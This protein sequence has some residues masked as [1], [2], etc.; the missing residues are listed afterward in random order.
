MEP[1]ITKNTLFNFF[2][3]NATPLQKR[4]IEQWLEEEAN[5][6]LFFEW[7]KQWE[8]EH[9]QFVADPEAAFQK[10]R[11]KRQSTRSNRHKDNSPIQPKR[12]VRY[13]AIAACVLLAFLWAGWLG[14]DL[15][16]WKT[17]RT[18]FG[19]LCTITL[20]EG[21]R[22]VLNANSSLAV[23]RF[24]FGDSFRQVKLAGEAQFS[25]KHTLSHQRFIVRTPDGLAVEVLGT[26]FVVYSRARGSRVVLQSG[27]VLIRNAANQLLSVA[28]GEVITLDPAGAFRKQTPRDVTMYSAWKDRRFVFDRTRLDEVAG[29]IEENFGVPVQL[30]HASLAGRSI[31]GTFRAQNAQEMIQMVADISGLVVAKK[32]KGYLLSSAAE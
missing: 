25:V 7:L 27:K 12:G 22:V 15:L 6:E 1:H 17:Y 30:A 11:A 24:G 13:W 5:R 21:S 3:G 8:N 18:G 16:L 14:K 29:L 28:P 2:S 31:S 10:L 4:V 20:Q 23:P 26:E 9:A 19:Q 32:D